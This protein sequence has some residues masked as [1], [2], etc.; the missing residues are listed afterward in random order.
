[1]ATLVHFF[2]TCKDFVPLGEEL[3]DYEKYR[4]Y[5]DNMSEWIRLLDNPDFMDA[6]PCVTSDIVAE[7]KKICSDFVKNRHWKKFLKCKYVYITQEELK[8]LN[9]F[10]SDCTVI[11][12]KEPEYQRD[13][14]LR[15][16][17]H[18]KDVLEIML[19]EHQRTTR[20]GNGY[21]D[22]TRTLVMLV[23][24]VRRFYK[25]LDNIPQEQRLV[26]SMATHPR[27]GEKSPLS[28]LEP[29]ILCMIAGY[30]G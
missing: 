2:N 3:C 12:N 25:K 7:M 9:F 14:F 19:R 10:V 24:W 18:M 26:L 28:E 21:D 1:M 4:K 16:M 13:R 20:R 22:R 6:T 23:D 29:E 17:D 5:R 11:A 15:P 27:L 30:L 8:Q